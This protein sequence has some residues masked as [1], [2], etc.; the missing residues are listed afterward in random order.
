MAKILYIVSF[1]ITVIVIGACSTRKTNKLPA[2]K[3]PIAII[4]KGNDPDLSSADLNYYMFKCL[5]ELEQFQRI[6]LTAVEPD[7]N[8]EIVLELDIS[9]FTI[10][11]KNQRVSRRVFTRRII[12]GEDAQGNPIY[13]TVRGS[14]DIVQ[15][16]WRAG[17]TIDSRLRIKG[18]P[19]KEFSRVFSPDYRRRY[20]Y[21]NNIQGDSRA[22]DRSLSGARVPPLDPEEHEILLELSR[23]EILDRISNEIR[24]YYNRK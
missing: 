6:E 7:E 23:E 5:D 24:S 20:I 14:A 13:G 10:W 4:I 21:V 19:G 22:L 15:E 2:Q 8:P 17:A 12:V 1:L 18:S 11:P 3:V 9:N 16:E